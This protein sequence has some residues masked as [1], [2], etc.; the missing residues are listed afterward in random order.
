[1]DNVSMK[2]SVVIPTLNEADHILCALD[3]I[4]CSLDGIF[5]VIV[6]D[7]GSTDGTE[8]ACRARPCRFLQSDRPG[9]GHQMNLGAAEASGEVLLFL[10]ADSRLPP[11]AAQA[12]Q[13]ALANPQVCGGG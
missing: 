2:I 8:E 5:E 9:R 12:I 6:V 7:G 13:S 11:D 3:S 1:M 10:H 4:S